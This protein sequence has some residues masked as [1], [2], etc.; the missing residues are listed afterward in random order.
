LGRIRNDLVSCLCGR[1]DRH[2]EHGSKRRLEKM[3]LI[4]EER[5]KAI[6]MGVPLPSISIDPS[7]P[8]TV[9]LALAD[10][11][12]TLWLTIGLTRWLPSMGKAGSARLSLL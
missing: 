9:G 1:A 10:V 11:P 5:M 2:L 3:T 8:W 4:H 6:E 12:L 7:S